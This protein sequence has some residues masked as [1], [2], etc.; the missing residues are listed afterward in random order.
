MAVCVLTVLALQQSL[1]IVIPATDVA[2]LVQRV[3]QIL[4]RNNFL[5][6]DNSA[7]F[8]NFGVG[9]STVGTLGGKFAAFLDAGEAEEMSATQLSN[10][11]G[12]CTFEVREANRTLNGRFVFLLQLH[13]VGHCGQ[14]S[15]LLLQ[16]FRVGHLFYKY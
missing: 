13:L 15:Q 9:G 3:V 5:N 7:A 10:G 11:F 2:R 6:F 1:K 4:S 12:V 14:P 8:Q 16:A